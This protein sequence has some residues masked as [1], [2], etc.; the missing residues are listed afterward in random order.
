MK[1]SV[2]SA[3]CQLTFLLG[4]SLATLGCAG[5]KLGPIAKT[6][7]RSV[8]VKMFK[9]ATYQPQLEAPITNAI[10]KRF[11]N[12]A[13][14]AIRSTDDADIVLSGEVTN[15]YRTMLRGQH[16]DTTVPAEIRLYIEVRVQVYER[17]TGRVI[18]PSAAFTAYTDTFTGRDQQSAEQ[19]ALPLI[20]DKLA[21]QVVARIVEP[22]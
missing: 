11:Q 5:Y 2:A 19:Q 8:A 22:W 16:L 1:S 20:A 18:L 7:Y 6:E 4:F 3:L 15:Y 14:L 17:N 21:R 12:D 13:T 9:N 10:I